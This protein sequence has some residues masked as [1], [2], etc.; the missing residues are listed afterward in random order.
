MK[1]GHVVPG[2][3][4]NKRWLLVAL[5]GAATASATVLVA[6][7]ASKSGGAFKAGGAPAAPAV[8]AVDPPAA[9]AGSDVP[10]P[11]P[12]PAGSDVPP[13]PPKPK[14][15]FAGC[16]PAPLPLPYAPPPAAEARGGGRSPG[17]KPPAKVG[18]FES[19][20]G[21]GDISSGFD[22]NYAKGGLLLD[23]GDTK[24][25][26]DGF[27]RSGAGFGAGCGGGTS[28]EGKSSKGFGRRGDQQVPALTLGQPTVQGGLDKVIVQRFVERKQQKLLYC[29]ERERLVKPNASG[30]IMARFEITP[31]GTVS[32]ANASGV[33]LNVASCVAQVIREI[34]FPEPKNGGSVQV[35]YPISF[36]LGGAGAA[37]APPAKVL[38][39]RAQWT[40]FATTLTSATPA[41]ASAVAEAT[42]TAL[43]PKLAAIEACVA[44]APPVAVRAMIIVKPDGTTSARVGGAGDAALESCVGT[45]LAGLT[46]ASAPAHPEVEVAC[47]ATRGE[48]PSWRVSPGAAY[49]IVEVTKTSFRAGGDA[50]AFADVLAKKQKQPPKSWPA[51]PPGGLYLVTAD[52]DAPMSHLGFVLDLIAAKRQPVMV[53]VRAGTEAPR[54]VLAIDDGAPDP[55]QTPRPLALQINAHQLTMCFPTTAAPG[56]SVTDPAAIDATLAAGIAACKNRV[57]STAEVLAAGDVSAAELLAVT[58]RVRRAGIEQIRAVQQHAAC[59]RPAAKP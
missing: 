57:Y 35:T 22:D 47:D 51:L 46:V 21:T 28:L 11:S 43:A 27:G 23:D 37:P 14:L 53:A 18:A 31:G 54:F 17:P 38:V 30:T 1:G 45:A 33:D 9:P 3:R 58:S 13:P 40:P 7:C 20:T 25:G 48:D 36:R 5:L 2:K 32:T 42:A 15:H 44:T 16:K 19:L 41:V 49:T 6:S 55:L 59:A 50:R 34:E 29:N 26:A 10:P 24:K 52:A 12:A 8:A 39:A 4:R 56:A